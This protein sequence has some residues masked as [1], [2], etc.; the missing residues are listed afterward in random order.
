MDRFSRTISLPTEDDTTRLGA[1]LAHILRRG[2]TVLLSGPVGSGKSALSR[3]VIRARLGEPHH[4]VPSPTYTLVQVYDDPTGIEIWHADLYRL[5]DP[6]EV[7]EL[8]LT[9]AFDSA[10]CLVEWPD[11][12]ADLRP[13]TALAIEM[14][15]SAGGH[16]ARLSGPGPWADRLRSLDD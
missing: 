1:A 15:G 12:L 11:R 2:D 6:A 3:A 16:T 7:E 10:I 13:A 14:A 9:E 5:S 4:E 8:G